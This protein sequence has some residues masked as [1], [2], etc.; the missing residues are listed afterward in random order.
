M[1]SR[2]M[3]HKMPE[4]PSLP[5]E[6]RLNPTPL[7]TQSLRASFQLCQPPGPLEC[8]AQV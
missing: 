3:P 5:V 2:H 8:H 6:R 7:L 4:D 1:L